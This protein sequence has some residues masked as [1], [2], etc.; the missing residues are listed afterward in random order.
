L[1]EALQRIGKGES[2]KVRRHRPNATPE[3]MARFGKLKVLL[4]E[5]NP[6]NQQVALAML[7]S[8]SCRAEVAV[9]GLAAIQAVQDHHYD[10]IFMDVQMP[11]MDGL[12]ATRRIRQQEEDG[13][14]S[15]IVAMTA[16]AFDRDRDE[17]LQAGMDDYATKPIQR[18]RLIEILLD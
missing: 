5:D 14:R 18:N 9:N 4:V 13:R 15:R 7:A 3:M 2:S 10:L 8:L 16:G 17:C 11:V 12:E 1:Y 6:V